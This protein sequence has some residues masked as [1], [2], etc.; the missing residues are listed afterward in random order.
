MSTFVASSIINNLNLITDTQKAILQ[1]FDEKKIKV[2]IGIIL[3]QFNTEYFNSQKV[4]YIAN[5]TI[6]L[7]INELILPDVVPHSV[8]G[9]RS[10]WSDGKDKTSSGKSFEITT[11][12]GESLAKYYNQKAMKYKFKYLRLK[13]EL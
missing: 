12:V 5:K 4:T 9:S 6:G 2:C 8:Y 10:G 1:S 7:K 3:K 11:P 13:G